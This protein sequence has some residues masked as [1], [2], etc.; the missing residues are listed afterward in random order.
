MVSVYLPTTCETVVHSGQHYPQV[1]PH[2]PSLQGLVLH[3][4]STQV[5]SNTWI[6]PRKHKVVIIMT[7]V[8]HNNTTMNTVRAET[9]WYWV[10]PLVWPMEYF[11][12]VQCDICRA[13]EHMRFWIE[14]IFSQCMYILVMFRNDDCSYC[15]LTKPLDFISHED[16]VRFPTLEIRGRLLGTFCATRA[17]VTTHELEQWA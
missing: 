12:D 6:F 2:L 5:S 7:W 16:S 3:L 15:F 8:Q 9:I 13:H 17:R 10:P 14:D 4:L 1:W 11:Q